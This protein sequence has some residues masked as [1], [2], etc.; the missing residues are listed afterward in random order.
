[1]DN[2]DAVHI[3]SGIMLSHK[4]EQNNMEEIEIAKKVAVKSYSGQEKQVT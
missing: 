1:M 4:K 2:E 3:Y